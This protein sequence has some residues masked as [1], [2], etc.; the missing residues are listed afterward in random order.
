MAG[1]FLLESIAHMFYVVESAM[2]ECRMRKG[3]GSV[4]DL[5]PSG[6]CGWRCGE[7]GERG[8]AGRVK[9]W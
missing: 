8:F 6:W 2:E 9:A 4:R 3:E 7:E 1:S 5:R